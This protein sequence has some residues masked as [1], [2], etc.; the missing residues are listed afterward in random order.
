MKLLQTDRSKFLTMMTIILLGLF[1]LRLFA[2]DKEET[3]SK[4]DRL[5]GKV[6][7]IT[8]RVDGKDVV[9]EGS[10]AQK[11]ADR[12]KSEKKIKIFSSGGLK[13]NEEGDDNV[14][15]FRSKTKGEDFD[16]N[17][18]DVKKKVK[19]EEKDG[20]KIVTITTIRDGTEE[21]K[22]YEGDEAE[23]FLNEEKG[24]K[25]ITVNM[26]DDEDM[27]KDHM[28]YFNSKMG[29]KRMNKHSCC[30]CGDMDMAP[31]HGK[32]HHKMMMKS[33]GNDDDES[34]VIIEKK[35]EKKESTKTEKK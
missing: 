33:D 24:M 28:V 7:K 16:I 2:Q 5:K 14:M 35:I 19:I 4:F 26:D 23:K 22:T 34:D 25:H 6:E 12:M 3:K 8:V 29:N 10:D 31:M 1:S 9:F 30:C 21:T 20:K 13:E 27:S 11:M 17:R 18:D 32:S 15:V